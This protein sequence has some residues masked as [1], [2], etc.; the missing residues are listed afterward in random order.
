MQVQRIAQ[1]AVN[2]AGGINVTTWETVGRRIPEGI[3]GGINSG[4]TSAVGAVEEIA[5]RS[6]E[7]GGNIN[8]ATWEEIGHRIPDGLTRGINDGSSSVVSAVERMARNAVEAA[9]R[10]LDIHSPSKK[11]EYMG[12]MSGEGYIAGW[13][14]TMLILIM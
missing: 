9:R 12:E 5:R 8:T 1:N 11:F 4:S 10:E 6:L 2:A 14:E 3:A 13:K 7:A